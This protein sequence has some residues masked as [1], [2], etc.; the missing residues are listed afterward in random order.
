MSRPR[1]GQYAIAHKIVE[2]MRDFNN[3][4]KKHG[5]SVRLSLLPKNNARALLA[6]GVG[7]LLCAAKDQA[8]LLRR[9]IDVLE[10]GGSPFGGSRFD[11][12]G[13]KDLAY[14]AAK[15]TVNGDPTYEE[16]AEEYCQRT[17]RILDRRNLKGYPLRRGKVGAPHGWRK[18][19]PPAFR[20]RAAS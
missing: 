8:Q 15:A 6:G 16:V 11:Q 5:K 1:K 20:R 2:L 17:G 13:A 12:H 7:L 10:G 14:Q 3:T 9:V 4:K 19:K 18:R